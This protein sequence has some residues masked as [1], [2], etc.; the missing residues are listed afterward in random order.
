MTHR[1][2]RAAVGLLLLLLLC[3]RVVFAQEIISLDGAHVAG[4][5]NAKVTLVEFADY[6]CPFCSR[7]FRE[8][9]PLIE[10]DYLR[11]G[12]VKYVFRDFPLE[13]S[14]P[15][16]FKAAVAAYCAGEQGKY[17]EMHARLFTHQQE[18][19]EKDLLR[20]A[21]M[22]GLDQSKFEGCL[23]NEEAAIKVRTELTEG[24]K[25]GVKVTPTFFLGFTASNGTEMQ[26][27][28]QIIGAQPYATF[29]EAL[30][31]LLALGR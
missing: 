26:V 3:A 1:C 9:F 21:Q 12:K 27:Y 19:F 2:Y 4:A 18:L 10:K 25:A 23:D 16:A 20:H 6:Q 30:D 15:R 28:Q 24:Q 11:P 13:H 7:H 29:K 14:H 22:I 5:K 17:W 8:T 31:G